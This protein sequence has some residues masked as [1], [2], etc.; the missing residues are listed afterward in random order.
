M[1]KP[2]PFAVAAPKSRLVLVRDSGAVDDKHVPDNRVVQ[3]MLDTA[4]SSFCGGDDVNVAWR[5]FI[6]TSDLVGIKITRCTWMRVGT[7]QAVVDA[8]TTR[9]IGIGLDHSQIIVR[10]GGMPLE[11]C[12]ALIN[13]PAIKVHAVTGFAGAL[14]NYINFSANPQAYHHENNVKLGEIWLQPEVKDKTRLVIAD[15]LRPYFGPGPQ[16][17]PTFRWDYRGIMVGTDP[18]AMDAAALAICQKKRELH[19]HE[20][21]PITPPPMQILGAER[22]YGLGVADP[23]QI[24]V[25][26]HGWRQGALI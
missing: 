4:I 5:Q 7:E 14:K 26:K 16:I 18:V 1:N 9:L 25:S 23:F 21:W 11:R 2:A 20:R 13:V 6:K 10:D 8:I 3:K 22:D 15:L 19:R 24:R 12:T 17:N